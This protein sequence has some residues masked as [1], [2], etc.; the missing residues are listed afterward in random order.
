MNRLVPG[1]AHHTCM[2]VVDTVDFPLQE[3]C[4]PNGK[5][6]ETLYS[7][8]FHGA[9]LRYEYCHGIY[10]GRLCWI[11][12]PFWPGDVNDLEIAQGFG[13]CQ[14]LRDSHEMG[15]ADGIY[16]DRCFFTPP[17]RHSPQSQAMGALRAR[18]ETVNSRMKN[19]RC[20][21]EKWR[22]DEDF[23]ASVVYACMNILELEIENGFTQL[24]DV[25][26]HPP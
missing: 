9:G 4:L 17:G 20:L 24:F 7:Y 11:N 22:Q 2:T 6:D 15:I 16:R 26:V 10:S 25:A 19:W 5:L 14:R 3:I 13:L 23:H 1:M 12:G 8:K 18:N 21:R